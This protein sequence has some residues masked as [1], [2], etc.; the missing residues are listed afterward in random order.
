MVLSG[1]TV[2]LSS[3]NSLIGATAVE[4]RVSTTFVSSSNT[5]KSRFNIFAIVLLSLKHFSF[6]KFLAV[7]VALAVAVVSSVFLYK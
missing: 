3:I 4:G 5:A 1:S 2:V 7:A 6:P